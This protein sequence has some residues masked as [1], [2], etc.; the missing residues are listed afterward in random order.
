MAMNPTLPKN[1]GWLPSVSNKG[2]EGTEIGKD[3][4]ALQPVMN[5]F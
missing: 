2:Y 1:S 4:A 5:N 3:C